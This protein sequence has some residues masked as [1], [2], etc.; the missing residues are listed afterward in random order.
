[1]MVNNERMDQRSYAL[2]LK[3]VPGIGNR[4]AV[5]VL[6]AFPTPQSLLEASSHQVE[7]L[8]KRISQALSAVSKDGFAWLLEKARKDVEDH[9]NAGFAVLSLFD[10]D[11]PP[12]LRLIPDAPVIVFVK[13]SLQALNSD[14]SIAIVGTRSPTAGGLEQAYSLAVQAANA[15]ITVVSGL[16][17]GIDTAAHKG[18]V[19]NGGKTV[20]VFGTAINKVYPAQNRSLAQRI[21]E[22]GGA[23]VSEYGMDEQTQRLSFVHR[24]RIQSA[25]SLAVV[26]VQTDIAGGTMHTVRFA[27]QQDRLIMCP[28]PHPEESNAWQTAGVR[29]LLDDGSAH[30]IDNLDEELINKLREH[31]ERLLHSSNGQRPQPP[32][33]L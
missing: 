23:L 5:T 29:R 3:S 10:R 16:A 8:G 13:G 6:T 4:S 26:A 2:A 21:V 11:Y 7:S 28:I 22:T 19:D 14:L 12:L 24:D 15:G 33:P 18:A 32:L 31:R 27:Q 25:L 20:A 1:M 17:L 9:L 30:A